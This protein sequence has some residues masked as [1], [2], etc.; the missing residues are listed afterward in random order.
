MHFGAIVDSHL[1]SE[2]SSFA[3][4]DPKRFNNFNVYVFPLFLKKHAGSPVNLATLCLFGKSVSLITSNSDGG[5][6]YACTVSIPGLI[7]RS[8]RRLVDSTAL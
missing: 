4:N 3:L 2:I 1:S 5:L 8:L 6:V 7:V